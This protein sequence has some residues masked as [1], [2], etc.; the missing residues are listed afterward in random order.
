MPVSG[1]LV[2]YACVAV[3]LR[4]FIYACA[5]VEYACVA[6]GLQLFVFVWPVWQ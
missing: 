6:I 4:I 5:A 2:L 1:K 3:E